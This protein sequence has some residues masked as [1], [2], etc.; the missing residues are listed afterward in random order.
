MGLDKRIS[1]YFLNPGPG[2]GGSCFPK[3]CQALLYIASQNNVDLQIVA[4]TLV[5]NELQKGLAV[6]KLKNL[7][8]AYDKNPKLTLHG[9][10]VGVLG[11][12]YKANTDDVRSSPS[13]NVIEMLRNEGAFIKAYDPAAMDNMRKFFPGLT[14]CSTP[15]ETA[16]HADAIV[17]MTEW[18]E[19]KNLDLSKLAKIMKAKIVVDM[20]NVIEREDLAQRGF[21]F[22]GCC[23]G[24]KK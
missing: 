16:A 13:I 14:Y 23:R 1:P 21:L 10:T 18:D 8:A 22:D 19:F 3:D 2:F 12:A 20:R 4:A 7:V 17:I 9:K 15:Y 11:L 6:T 24:F 5:A